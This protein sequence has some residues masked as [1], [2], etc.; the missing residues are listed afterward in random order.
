[1]R[2]R[3]GYDIDIF[4]NKIKAGG[5]AEDQAEKMLNSEDCVCTR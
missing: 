2:T 1:M 3:G 5:Q 4:Y